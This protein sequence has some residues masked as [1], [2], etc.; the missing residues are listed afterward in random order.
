LREVAG[1]VPRRH[2]RWGVATR[3]LKYIAGTP[4]KASAI[5]CEHR[6]TLDM[7]R[8]GIGTRT[9]QRIK[10]RDVKFIRALRAIGICSFGHIPTLLPNEGA[11]ALDIRLRQQA[12]QR[13]QPDTIMRSRKIK[14]GASRRRLRQSPGHCASAVVLPTSRVCS[15]SGGKTN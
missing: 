11:K 15:N 13:P 9:G 12:L 14:E 3:L 7:L 5:N 4:F 8:T 2:C 1:C 6:K 10:P